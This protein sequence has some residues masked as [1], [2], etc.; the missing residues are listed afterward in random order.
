MLVNQIVETTKKGMRIICYANNIDIVMQQKLDFG[1]MSLTLI[2]EDG[3]VSTNSNRKE[4]VNLA[5]S[6]KLVGNLFSTINLSP[7]ESTTAKAFLTWYFP[8]TY[9]TQNK[10]KLDGNR[11]F[12]ADTM[13][14]YS[15]MYK[16]ANEV[17]E[18][19]INN[20]DMLSGN[21]KKWHDTWYNSTLP[22]WFLDRTFLNTSILAS[23][24]IS[25]VGDKMYYGTEGGN[26]GPGTCTHVY[27]YTQAPGRLFPELEQSIREQVDFVPVEKGGALM[28]NG[29]VHFRWF[30]MGMAVD[31]QSGIIMKSYQI[32]QMSANDSFLKK[33]YASI[34]KIMNG[35]IEHNDADHD[36]ILTGGQHNTL[37]AD[38][39]GKVTWLSLYYTAA[40]R[41]MGAMAEDIGDAEYAEF[42][43]ATAENG[44]NY[45]EHHL[46]NGEY[47]FHE[48]DSLHPDS[49]GTYTGLEY[50]QLLGQSWAYQAGLGVILDSAKVRTALA[51]MWRYN[52]TTDVDTFRKVHPTG[53][54]YAM[55]G[56]GGL[57]ACTWPQGGEE[58]LDKGD[59][60]F[61]AYNNECQNGYEYAATSTMMWHGMPYHSLAHIWYMD[62]NRYHGSKRNPYCEIEWGLHY[63][64][65]MAS[66]G[67]FIAVSGFDYHGPKGYIA[68]SPKITPHNFKS[69]FTAA[70]GWGT[71]RQTQSK[72]K[73]TASISLAYGKLNLN[74]LALTIPIGEVVNK[75]MVK[76]N[77][78]R[79][80]VESHQE[81]NKIMLQLLSQIKIKENDE[82]SV[83]LSY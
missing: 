57:I 4:T 13:R 45:I 19:L 2:S 42:C 7:N 48:G 72:N 71:F 38:W 68:F 33:N 50:S 34:K 18:Y 22:Y 16:D 23:S 35:L 11:I 77:N 9:A 37:D 66:Y 67:H 75:V 64:R 74:K 30:G 58:V 43:R 40:L 20:Y 25:L 70:E 56:E 55:P 47:F 76:H 59:P 26:Q 78:K 51:S 6:S 39:Y 63:A 5:E 53:R 3:L 12:G 21:T 32:H 60:R 80:K 62:Q 27:G 28:D 54:W 49:P 8:K 29:V 17:S 81:E 73:Q 83:Q 24:T 61:A 69:A 46:F 65:S 1:S 44:K 41:A 15:T 36:G 82:L 52:F 10:W 31:G 79:I 14:Y